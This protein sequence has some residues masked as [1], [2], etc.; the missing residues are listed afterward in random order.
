MMPTS[1]TN[2]VTNMKQFTLIGYPTLIFNVAKRYDYF[3]IDTVKG[4]S[5]DG[6]KQTV[7]RV[8]DVVAA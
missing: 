6:K 2:G 7:A 1:T 5:I 4:V 3:G 8:A